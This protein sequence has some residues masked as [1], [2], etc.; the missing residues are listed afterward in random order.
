MFDRTLQSYVPSYYDR[1]VEMD[2]IIAAEQP[3]MTAAQRETTLAFTRGFVLTADVVGI[4]V[5]EQ[6][7]G[8]V[9]DPSIEDL[10]FRRERILNRMSMRL[11]FT[12]RYLVN[13]LNQFLG[14]GQYEI[15][16]DHNS[17]SLKI[18]AHTGIPNK[19][20]ELVQTLYK[21]VPVNI[22][23]V[24]NNE[25]ICYNESE[26]FYGG[27]LK[28]L[29]RYRL[30]SD[31]T[32]GYNLNGVE[33][34]GGGLSQKSKVVLTSDFKKSYEVQSPMYPAQGSILNKKYQIQ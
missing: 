6:M 12:Y 13:K 19:V 20:E 31:F 30:T 15:E 23:L 26:S 16:L 3:M 28:S 4:E 17:Y 11:P 24:V 14:V 7:L 27:A 34:H 29:I 22:I 2:A 25:L 9:A 18:V 1:V 10:E 5:F 8:I 33:F 32:A 21:I